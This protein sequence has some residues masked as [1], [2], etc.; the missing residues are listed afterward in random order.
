[1]T[2]GNKRYYWLKLKEDFFRDKKIKKLRNIAGGDTYTIIYLKMQLLSLKNE[3]LLFFEGVENTFEEEI[4]LELDENIDDVKMCVMYLLK[5][6]LMEIGENDNYIMLQTQES[7]GS[8]TDSTIRSRKSRKLKT[9]R[10]KL[11]QC[12]TPATKCNGDIDI[13]LDK[14][15][16]IYTINNIYPAKKNE[17]A[18]KGIDLFE[19][20]WEAY[21]K[22]R[23]KVSAER[24]FNKNKPT[25]ELVELMISKIEEFKKTFQ[26]QQNDGQYIPYPATWLNSKAWEDILEVETNKID[27]TKLTKDIQVQEATQEEIE[28]LERKINSIKNH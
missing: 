28:E 18:Y 23:D 21:P 20:F 11:L 4:A 19:M 27:V 10:E 5:N 12:N 6:N 15:I 26:W 1:M 16:D 25:K 24:W 14:E 7:I 3:G 2:M 8:E 22:K 13:E 17:E 9:E